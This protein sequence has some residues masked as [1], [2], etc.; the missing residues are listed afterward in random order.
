MIYNESGQ[1]CI[2]IE[3][4]LTAIEESES[5]YIAKIRGQLK[6]LMP[7]VDEF[8][9][10]AEE[11]NLGSMDPKS[12]K[13]IKKM[14]RGM[15]LWTVIL[16]ILEPISAVI[17]IAYLVDT[18]NRFKSYGGESKIL[19]MASWFVVNVVF[20]LIDNLATTQQSNAIMDLQKYY[21]G[22]INQC[23]CLVQKMMKMES[24]QNSEDKN[25][26]IEL[27]NQIEDEIYKINYLYKW[28]VSI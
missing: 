25:K 9:K 1:E 2:I 11:N 23:R 10:I 19:S 13:A 12:A 7:L 17:N 6:I 21:H 22:A 4:K 5:P 16:K 3:N 24:F 8:Q 26:L 20:C 28:E 18:Y 27:M 14:K 15:Y